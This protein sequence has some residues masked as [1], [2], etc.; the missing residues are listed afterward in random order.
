MMEVA[1]T[2]IVIVVYWNGNR[3]GDA[4]QHFYSQHPELCGSLE[5][6]SYD[7]ENSTLQTQFGYRTKWTKPI[8]ARQVLE[9]YG[10]E[11]LDVVARGIGVLSAEE[12]GVGRECVSTCRCGRSAIAKQ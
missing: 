2:G 10:A 1:E 9:S 11:V 6:A 7:W 3:F 8:E 12:G 4:V 5:G